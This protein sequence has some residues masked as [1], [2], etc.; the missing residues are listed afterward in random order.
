MAKNPS[1]SS[2][3]EK[4]GGEAAEIQAMSSLRDDGECSLTEQEDG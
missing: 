4:E 1:R 3:E 2:D